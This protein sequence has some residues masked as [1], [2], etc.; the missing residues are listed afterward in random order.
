VEDEKR[1]KQLLAHLFGEDSDEDEASDHTP[2]PHPV[3]TQT[4]AVKPKSPTFGSDD[5]AEPTQ[6]ASQQ[7]S[8]DPPASQPRPSPLQRQKSSGGVSSAPLNI[9]VPAM[10][11]LPEEAKVRCVLPVFSS[12]FSLQVNF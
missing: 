11:K 3:S 5:E 7:A 9:M 6:K 2:A 1:K 4:P 8:Q 10:P 12:Q